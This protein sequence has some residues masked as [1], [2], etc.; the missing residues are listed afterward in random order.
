MNLIRGGRNATVV[1]CTCVCPAERNNSYSGC[2]KGGGCS[3]STQ[4]ES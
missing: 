4:V 3:E 1:G 2:K